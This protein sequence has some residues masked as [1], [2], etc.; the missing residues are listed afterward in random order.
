MLNRIECGKIV[1][2]NYA[3]GFKKFIDAIAK[4]KDRIV[5]RG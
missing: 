1:I 2:L 4:T 5:D 3:P